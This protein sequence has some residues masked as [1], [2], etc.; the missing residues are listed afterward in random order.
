L[1]LLEKD[2]LRG[3][4][5]RSARWLAARGGRHA[6]S[7]AV[8]YAAAAGLVVLTAVAPTVSPKAAVAGAAAP[9]AAA[10]AG[11]PDS[12]AAT[13]AATASAGALATGAPGAAAAAPGVQLGANGRPV[14]PG[15]IASASDVTRIARGLEPGFGTTVAGVQ[16]RPGVRQT[17]DIPYA[18]YCVP[19]YVGPNGGST[20]QGVTATTI[21]LCFREFN[22]ASTQAGNAAAE[23]ISGESQQQVENTIDAY[24]KYFNTHYDF[25]GRQIVLIRHTGHGS[26]S[27]ETTGGGQDNA[28]ADALE[29]RDKGGFAELAAGAESEVYTDALRNL[30][31]QPLMSVAGPNYDPTEWYDGVSPYAWDMGMDCNNVVDIEANFIGRNLG[32]GNARHAGDPVYQQSPRKFGLLVPDLPSYAH[33]GD[34]LQQYLQQRYG[35]TLTDRINYQLNLATASAQ[36][37]NY[38]ATFKQ[39]G[40]TSLILLTDDFTPAFMTQNADKAQ[41][42]PEWLISGIANVD[43]DMIGRAYQKDQWAHALGPSILTEKAQNKNTADGRAA[44]IAATGSANGY[45]Y[46]AEG[47]FRAIDHFANMLQMAGPDLTPQTMQ[48]GIYYFPKSFGEYGTMYFGPHNHMVTHDMRLVYWSNTAV[49][50]DGVVGCYVEIDGGK[51][52]TGA[53]WPSGDPF[54]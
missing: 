18:P 4:L 3:T 37:Q 32:K 6:R 29:C 51:R 52:W 13:P 33:C 2:A 47:Y 50:A 35:I 1:V 43:V 16:C 17:S 36:T 25:Y 40:V 53:D 38:V 46:S 48:Q 8:L 28:R 44:Y 26:Y 19:H 20:Y 10:G 9:G 31:P 23:G 45:A 49:G 12:G 15:A 34:L 11:G 21:G 14:P 7:Y 30:T 5:R 41:W 22:D 24:V 27:D 54:P 42:Y 39:D